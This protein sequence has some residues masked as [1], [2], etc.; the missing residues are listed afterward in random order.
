MFLRIWKFLT[1]NKALISLVIILAAFLRLYKIGDYMTFL[2]DEGRDALIVKGILEGHLTLLGPRASAGDFFTGPI[3]YYFMAPFL[4]LFHLDPVGPAVGIA[5]LGIATVYLAYRMGKYF[6]GAPAGILAAALYAVSPIVISYSRSS[7]NPNPMPFLSLLILFFLYKSVV[8][9]SWKTLL[10]TGLLFGVAMQLHYIEVFLGITIFIFLTVSTLMLENKERVRKIIVR[11]AE[12]LLGFLIGFSP[13]L[14][15]E[16]RHGFPNTKAVFS[17]IFHQD[18]Y[19]K[20]AINATPL[21]IVKDVFL[22]LF[23]RLLTNSSP[24]EQLYNGLFVFTWWQVG[25]LIL[26]VASVIAL[27]KIKN[28]LALLLFSL[29][30]FIGVVS[31]G[32]YKKPVYD[33]YFEFM[34]PLPFLLVGNLFYQLY[35]SKKLR[36]YGKIV[37]VG[38]F[39]CLFLYS[40][41]WMPFKFAPN[42]QKDQV[43]SIAEFVVSKTNN[44]PFNFALIAGQNSDH[45]YRYFL[46]VW[47]RDP[48][49][50]ENEIVDPKRTT[51]TG[52]LI[53]VCEDAICAPLGNS[54]W[55]IAGFGRAEIVGEWNVSVVKVFKLVHYTGK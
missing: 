24:T 1:N 28:K 8:N 47:K 22:R 46:D 49:V 30:L 27:F 25:I 44:Q 35:N 45:A 54:L 52:Q 19:V 6:F 23:G 5:L 21:Q 26:A 38:L 18:L 32:F 40:L 37:S 51:V 11:Y 20:Q 53:V 41:Y 14:G 50:I 17:F 15:F 55:E 16:V 33:Y 3:Y 48:I 2:G 9:R 13:F 4:W 39:I 12:F 31:F 10:I 36:I 42:K 34:F 43:K 7:W 29:W